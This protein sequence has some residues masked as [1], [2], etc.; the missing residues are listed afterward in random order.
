MYTWLSWRALVLKSLTDRQPDEAGFTA[1]IAD[2]VR[3]AN[4]QRR[5]DAQSFALQYNRY[6]SQRRGLVG[7]T[8]TQSD[9]ALKTAVKLLLRDVA[10]ASADTLM[11]AAIADY[12][13]VQRNPV[14]QAS[15]ARYAEMRAKLAGYET[16]LADATVQAAVKVLLRD[17][18]SDT[19]FAHAVAEYL[20][21]QSG[22]NESRA[23]YAQLRERLGG[24]ATTQNDAAL[25]AA[26]RSSLADGKRDDTEFARAVA[27]Y[28]RAELAREVDARDVESASGA[29]AT[30][31]SCRAD[32]ERAR[33]RLAGYSPTLSFNQAAVNVFLPVD[34][35]RSNTSTYIAGLTTAATEDLKAF[36]TWIDA[37]IATAKADLTGLG[38]WIDQQVITAKAD[39]QGAGAWIDQQVL[40]AKADLQALSQRIQT[41]IRAGA[42]ELQHYIDGY[43]VGHTSDYTEFDATNEGAAHKVELPDGAQLREAWIKYVN[44]ANPEDAID[45]TDEDRANWE[46]CATVAWADR[47]AKLIA[48]STSRPQIAVHPRATE[49]LFT[50]QLKD[51]EIEL[52]LVY[53]GTKLEFEDGDSVPLDEE[54]AMAVAK[55]INAELAA[56][57]GEP[58]AQQQIWRAGYA[59]ERSRLYLKHKNR[60]EL[61]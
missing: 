13:R 61:K 35:L 12:V 59:S 52:H 33:L 34:N 29:K 7:Y 36:G 14:D 5:G 32:Y 51:R 8:T 22:D 53:D 3:A 40:S 24:Y 44:A 42:I 46:P 37:Q 1:A 11:T 54:A 26:V 38:T 55:R 23:R 16:A 47:Q 27:L 56:E 60:A 9:S 15:A 58:I 21:G 25:Q 20:R 43:R 45:D 48:S 2:Y 6:K 41:E 19:L 30:Y 10:E 57:W 31:E 4:S 49:I 39:L 50:P 28:V 17:A 18:P